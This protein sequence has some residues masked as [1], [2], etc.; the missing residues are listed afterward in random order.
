MLESPQRMLSSW[1]EQ[2]VLWGRAGS[3]RPA[4]AEGQRWTSSGAL[5]GSFWGAGG[6][7]ANVFLFAARPDVRTRRAAATSVMRSECRSSES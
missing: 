2:S 4:R 1:L 7:E 3:G 6:L 5:V